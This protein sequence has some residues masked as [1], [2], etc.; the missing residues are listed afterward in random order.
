VV[1]AVATHRAVF[2]DAGNV[3]RATWDYAQVLGRVGV[4]SVLIG[5]TGLLLLSTVAP[6]A[7]GSKVSPFG[8]SPP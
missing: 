7:L 4:A 3:Y 6:G 5:I 1:K 2:P 8:P